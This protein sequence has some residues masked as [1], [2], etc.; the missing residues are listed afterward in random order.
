MPPR[1][2]A[3]SGSL[4]KPSTLARKAQSSPRTFTISSA[5]YKNPLA[6]RH[7]GDLGSHLPKFVIPQDAQM[8]E[9]PY[10]PNELFKQSNKGLYG[11]KMIQF[12]NNVSHK[13]ETKT[14][15]YWKP[16]VL[17]KSLYSVALKKRIK[18]RITSN[19]LKTIDREGGLD[20]Y[21]LKQTEGRVKELGPLGW[22]L[23][24]TLLQKPS[25]IRRMRSDAA[26]LGVPQEE[27]DRQWPE[28]P[29]V[30]SVAVH[31][32]EEAAQAAFEKE[33]LAEK[34][35]QRIM[36]KLTREASDEYSLAHKV[37]NR[38]VIRGTVDT[39]EQGM[40]LGFLREQKRAESRALNLATFKTKLEAQYNKE[41]KTDSALK[42]AIRRYRNDV[43][44]QIAKA[45]DY[46][47][48][49]EKAN[50]EAAAKYA[51]AV[52]A[53]GGEE[54]WKAAKRA[55]TAKE[56]NEAE[57]ALSNRSLPEEE[58]LRIQT[59][60]QKAQEVINAGTKEA[61]VDQFVARW[62]EKNQNQWPLNSVS[63]EEAIGESWE[64]FEQSG[65]VGAWDALVQANAKETTS[66]QPQ[67]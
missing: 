32:A 27:I 60:L 49:R 13:T 31:A 54:A 51:A 48:F 2:L 57:N 3:L 36:G 6:R 11:G 44:G 37:A 66:S 20:E 50:P 64:E 34:D 47:T 19:V 12:G 28:P 15:R 65:N 24:W 56:I 1:C 41:L 21:L 25:V 5:L 22:A 59:A 18:L 8:P 30:P 53:A 43:Q 62:E 23:R 10:G 33:V 16:N 58:R 52:E 26:A 35:L 9:Y 67:A 46:K 39:I 38:Y 55:H 40:K 14:R 42:N 17:S 4:S 29:E 63:K 45:G 61:Y 7:G